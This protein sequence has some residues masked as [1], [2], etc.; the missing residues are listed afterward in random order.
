MNIFDQNLFV[1]RQLIFHLDSE[2]KM[3]E[4]FNK[5]IYDNIEM[6]LRWQH[7]RSERLKAGRMVLLSS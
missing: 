3:K 7:C 6:F 2:I 5:F 1:K 4:I